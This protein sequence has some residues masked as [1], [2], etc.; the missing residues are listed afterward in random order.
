MIGEMESAEAQRH[1]ELMDAVLTEILLK[2]TKETC[3]RERNGCKI[4]HGSQK[5]HP[6][7][8]WEE[9]E[10]VSYYG[11]REMGK[12]FGEGIL[13]KAYKEAILVLKWEDH[14]YAWEH[15]DRLQ[16]DYETMLERLGKARNKEY[17]D[18]CTYIYYWLDK[19]TNC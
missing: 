2:N 13:E 5:Q 18:L 15:Y 17:K 6:C 11:L 7:V 1:C 16:S 12:V 10:Y 4:N 3:V 8:T 9:N 14:V 19:D